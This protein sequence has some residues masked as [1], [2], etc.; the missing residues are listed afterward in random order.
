MYK[1]LFLLSAHKKSS[2]VKSTA[3]NLM[4]YIYNYLFVKGYSENIALISSFIA[5]V[6]V[7]L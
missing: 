6:L 7:W 4:E 2:T 5:L 1:I 3:L